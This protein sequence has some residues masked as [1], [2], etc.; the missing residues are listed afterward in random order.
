MRLHDKVAIITGAGRG[1]GRATALRFAEEGAR[2]VCADLDLAF[3]TE[4]ADE[5]NAR[6]RA[7]ANGRAVHA[8]EGTSAEGNGVKPVLTPTAYALPVRVNVADAAS[9]R[10]M[11]AAALERYGRVD[12]MV[13]NAGI[14]RD[15][16]I[17]K[18]TED[19]FDSV[20][21]VNLKGVYNCTRA[22]A[23]HM[24]ERGTGVILSTAS[25]VA[26]YGNF[27]QTNY[28]AAKAG[29]VGMTKVWAR[30]LGRKGI[31]VNAVAPGFIRTRMTEG[32]PDKVMDAIEQRIP[33]GY[34]GEP[35]DIANAFLWLASDEARYV[36]GH[37]LAVDGGAV[38]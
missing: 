3:V 19:E 25:I 15:A 5:I 18:M 23:E 11:V 1:I 2:V 16:R 7:G 24:S 33:L 10:A 26:T 22:V 12:I 38:I 27:G 4:V 9:C 31:R 17:V 6:A 37:V 20:I 29:V 8:A 32:I 34:R 21:D 36:S 13:N 28:V 14:V 35:E 30:E